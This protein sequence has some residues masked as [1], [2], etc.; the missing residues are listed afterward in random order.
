MTP[1]KL[2]VVDPVGRTAVD[3]F[4]HWRSILA[5]VCRI[6]HPR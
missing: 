5:A 2:V 1:T 3:M 4:L 6:D